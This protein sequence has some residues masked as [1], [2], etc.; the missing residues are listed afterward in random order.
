MVL[1]LRGGRFGIGVEPPAVFFTRAVH[2]YVNVVGVALPRAR[3]G[4]VAFHQV[5][6][7]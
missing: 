1:D 6:A 2:I 5:G 7:V 4:V 3:R